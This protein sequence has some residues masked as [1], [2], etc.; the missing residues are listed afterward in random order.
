[1]NQAIDYDA[2]Y[3][4]LNSSGSIE[5]SMQIDSL[6]ADGFT[7]HM[8]NADNA[9]NFTWALSVGG[10]AAPAATAFPWLYYY[11]QRQA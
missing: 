5:G 2:V 11:R 6:D 3:V 4:H 1:M 10:S 7:A 8:D 9:A